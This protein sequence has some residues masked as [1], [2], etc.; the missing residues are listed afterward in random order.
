MFDLYFC[1]RVVRQL[2]NSCDASMLESFLGY[3][4][5]RGH[6]RNTVHQY[7]W[8]TKA[9]LRSLGRTRTSPAKPSPRLPL[10]ETSLSSTPLAGRRTQT[11]FPRIERRE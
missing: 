8:A 1:P 2:Q 4:D 6:A 10:P 9:L 5:R 11:A 3:L 7:M